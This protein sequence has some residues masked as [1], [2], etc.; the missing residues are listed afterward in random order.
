MYRNV[1]IMKKTG[2]KGYE[3]GKKS[4]PKCTKNKKTEVKECKNGKN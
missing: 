2:G 3:N 1:P 4:V